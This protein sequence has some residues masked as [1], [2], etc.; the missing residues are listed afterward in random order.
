[1]SKIFFILSV[2]LTLFGASFSAKAASSLG[3]AGGYA[4]GINSDLHGSMKTSASH[5]VLGVNYLFDFT[6]DS[7]R[8]ICSD[9][10]FEARFSWLTPKT[11]EFSGVRLESG[12][13]GG[14]TEKY[15]TY[16]FTVGARK[17]F[18]L[19]ETAYA[20]GGGGLAIDWVNISDADLVDVLG[21][22]VNFEIN[23][24]GVQVGISPTLGLGFEIS[25]KLSIEALASTRYYFGT[26]FDQTFFEFPLFLRFKF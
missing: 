7:L 13:L 11:Y 25:H 20:I 22:S 3:V 17:H 23:G 21:N 4:R 5:G 19:S 8:N 1:M 26:G 10:F 2:V 18:Y 6:C 14:Y 9:T 24:S 15:S 16:A 12:Q